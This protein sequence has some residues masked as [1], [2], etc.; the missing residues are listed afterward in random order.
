ME[1]LDLTKQSEVIEQ[2]ALQS[3]FRAADAALRSALG[4]EWLS[5]GQGAALIAAGLPSSAIVVNRALGLASVD[6]AARAAAAYRARG[7]ARFFLNGAPGPV[8]GLEPAR[9]WRKFHRLA[10]A[11]LPEA[12]VPLPIRAL[13]PDDGPAFAR[14]VCAAFDLGVVA[15]PW[16]ARLPGQPGWRFFGA[17][18]GDRL[19]GTGG[20]YV[21]GDMGWTDWGATDPAYRGQGVQRSLLTHRV[22][23][24]GQGGLSWLHT[25][26]GDAIPGEPQHSYAN[27]LR[28]GYVEG[29]TRANLAPPRQPLA[30]AAGSSLSA[31]GLAPAL[32]SS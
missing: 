30:R 16:L 1:H 8:P 21:R 26:T 7:V 17:F 9:S 31:R 2:A 4:I 19:A 24:A 28:C 10:A 12:P 32:V 22:R 23:L 20:I 18:D 5:L 11:P 25:C 27:I 3:L 29:A 13:G 15:E 14:V 6:D